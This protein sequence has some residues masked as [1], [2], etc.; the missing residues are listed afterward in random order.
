MVRRASPVE[1]RRVCRTRSRKEIVLIK[2]IRDAVSKGITVRGSGDPDKDKCGRSVYGR[3]AVLEYN[4]PVS[5]E[6]Q[7]ACPL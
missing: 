6:R 2:C 4:D 7:Y 1:I 3:K 5:D